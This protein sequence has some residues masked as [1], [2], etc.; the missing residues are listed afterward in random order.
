MFYAH[1]PGCGAWVGSCGWEK[2]SSALSRACETRS[3]IQ[4]VTYSGSE[5]FGVDSGRSH[6]AEHSQQPCREK[7]RIKS[8]VIEASLT[9]HRPAD[10][11][12]EALRY[13]SDSFGMRCASPL[14][15]HF[16]GEMVGGKD[17]PKWHISL[18]VLTDTDPD[19]SLHQARPFR[20]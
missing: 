18:A 17:V 1:P 6:S 8:W 7:G 16:Q 13:I 12:K 14:N 2:H 20:T 4:N 5:R 15:I 9:T 10:S 11:F 3:S 19:P